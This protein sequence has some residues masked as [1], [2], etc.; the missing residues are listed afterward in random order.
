MSEL[1]ATLE[2]TGDVSNSKI[3]KLGN[4]TSIISQHT[5][6]LTITVKNGIISPGVVKLFLFPHQEKKGMV[7][8]LIYNNRN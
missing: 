5:Y 8:Y 3:L 6:R 4:V 2:S 7:T 1:V